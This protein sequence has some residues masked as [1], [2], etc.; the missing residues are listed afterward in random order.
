MTNLVSGQTYY[1]RAYVVQAGS[2]IYGNVVSF[3]TNQDPTVFTDAVSNLTP[4]S[5]G[6]IITSWNVTFNGHIG[7]AGSPAF[8]EK[9]FCYGTSMNPTGNRQIVSGSG[10]GS[11]TKSITGLQNYQTYYVRA[12]AKTASGVYVYG[13]N[14][15]FQT[16]DW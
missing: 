11:F 10:T 9:G 14:V 2:P 16:F 1:V 4:V 3:S 12:Y 8:V 13:Q 6:G 15:S 5:S 7:F